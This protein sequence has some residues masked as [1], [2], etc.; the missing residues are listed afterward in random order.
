MH[1]LL[2]GEN[3]P[4]PLLAAA[5][6]LLLQ[7][8]IDLPPA[9]IRNNVAT[10]A[11][12]T[13]VLA[14]VA[15]EHHSS[16]SDDNNVNKSSNNETKST[17]TAT[18]DNAHP[19]H[20]H[21]H[22]LL[23]QLPALQYGMDVNPKYTAGLHGYEYTAG[24]Q[25]FDTLGVSLCHG[26]LLDPQ[27]TSED[28]YATIGDKTYNQVI[29]LVIH[30]KEAE[31]ALPALQQQ[32][33]SLEATL[34]PPVDL[35]DD[36][37]VVNATTGAAADGGSATTNADGHEKLAALRKK[38]EDM[39]HQATMGHWIDHFLQETGHQ[40][41]QYGLHQIHQDLPEDHLAVFFRN[42][43]FSTITKHE[44][45]LYLL[46]TDL[47]YA[48]TPQI[49]WEKLDMINGDTEHVNSEFKTVG[50]VS[51]DNAAAAAAATLSPEALLAQS[52][53]TEADYQLAM[54]LSMNEG[55]NN[56]NNNAASTNRSTLDAREG[57]LMAAATEASLLEYHGMKSSPNPAAVVA[58]AGTTATPTVAT[59]VPLGGSP[60]AGDGTRVILPPK[61]TTNDVP[62]DPDHLLALQL[63]QQQEQQAGGGGGGGYDDMASLRL[64]QQLQAEENQRAAAQ[65]PQRTTVSTRRP[66][67]G[68][69]QSNCVIS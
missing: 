44:G 63:A 21:T 66:A 43:H 2:Q 59:G 8:R 20:F 32:I 7:G 39:Q 5:N 12:L 42:N 54:H 4:C 25:V 51:E 29:E 18:N 49:V 33:Q 50:Q 48:G 28:L 55:G 62:T 45:L 27:E 16:T 1:H 60:S 69:K 41:T 31:Q 24:I 15:L 10:L 53:Q 47:G 34:P 65:Q 52:G 67:Q 13:N 11:D 17:T 35:L 56:S 58:S 30:G 23:E 3:G 6:V 46:V 40:L 9:S 37:N 36:T 14:N 38:Y 22:E 68:Q 26:W 61:P 57:Q 19:S 64:A